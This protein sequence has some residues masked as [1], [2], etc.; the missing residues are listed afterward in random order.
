[1]K[2]LPVITGQVKNKKIVQLYTQIILKEL[3][4]HRLRT[5]PLHIQFKKHVDGAQGMCDGNRHYCNI[6]VATYCPHTGRKLGFLEMMQTLTHEL[7][8]A[9]QFIRGELSNDCKWVWKGRNADGYDY[10]NQPWE[11][12]AYKLEKKLFAEN[13]P[14]CLP[15][16][17]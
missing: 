8:H 12:E 7:V 3:G 15:F 16:K 14:W 2:Y 11:K 5:F 9:R 13:F 10:Y 1:M 6:E 17:N 4:L